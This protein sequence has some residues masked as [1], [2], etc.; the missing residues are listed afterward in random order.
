MYLLQKNYKNFYEVI[1]GNGIEKKALKILK[2]RK[3]LRVIDSSK[4]NKIIRKY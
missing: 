4:L 1:I 3:N 2:K